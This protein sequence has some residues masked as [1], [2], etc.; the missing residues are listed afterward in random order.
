MLVEGPILGEERWVKSDDQRKARRLLGGC[1]RL[2]SIAGGAH[3]SRSAG[4]ETGL[5]RAGWAGAQRSA[6]RRIGI[7]RARRSIG[8]SQSIRVVCWPGRGRPIAIANGGSDEPDFTDGG[9]ARGSLFSAAA[10]GAAQT[11]KNIVGTYSFVHEVRTTNGKEATVEAKGM[12]VLDADGNYTLTISLLEHDGRFLVAT[13]G[14]H[15]Q[16]KHRTKPG[17]VIVAGKASDDMAPGTLNDVLTQAGLREA[18]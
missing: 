12:L 3:F 16:Y 2:S 18:R 5:L 14:S 8:I 4:A 1:I 6:T 13:R 9:D 11:A 10:P 17:R 7:R 15:R